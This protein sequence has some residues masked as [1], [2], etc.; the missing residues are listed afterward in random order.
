M[1][2]DWLSSR[3]VLTLVRRTSVVAQHSL[4]E[5]LDFFSVPDFRVAHRLVERL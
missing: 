1:R 4:I 2:G 3:H 5:T